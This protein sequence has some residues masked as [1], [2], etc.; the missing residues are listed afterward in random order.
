[1]LRSVLR[2]PFSAP[3]ACAATYKHAIA[4]AGRHFSASGA[5]KPRYLPYT[6]GEIKE[7]SSTGRRVK[8]TRRIPDK[9]EYIDT[10][11]VLAVVGR[12]NVGKSTL[13]N[14][15]AID[16]GDREMLMKSAGQAIA[17]FVPS[18]VDS[19]PGVTR[20]ARSANALLVDL[21]FS[22][23]DT[24]GLEDVPFAEQETAF[25]T[26]QRDETGLVLTMDEDY[27]GNAER[28]T[29]AIS[30]SLVGVGAMDPNE[31]YRAMYRGMLGSTI[32]AIASSDAIMLVVDLSCGV[33]PEDAALTRWVRRLYADKDVIL[34]GNKADAAVAKANFLDVYELGFGEPLAISAEQNTGFE[35]VYVRIKELYRKAVKD[36]ITARPAALGSS[37]ATEPRPS[38][39]MREAVAMERK[40]NA[41]GDI[42]DLLFDPDFQRDEPIRKPI[43]A[44]LGRPNVGKSTLMNRLL[45]RDRTLISPAAGVTRDAVLTEWFPDSSSKESL[46]LVDTAGVRRQTVTAKSRVERLSTKASFQALRTCHIAVLVMDA[47]QPLTDQDMRILDV[48]ITEGRAIVL[49]LNKTDLLQN[50]QTAREVREW[51]DEKIT[52]S[53]HHI[54]GVEVVFMSGKDWSNGRMQAKKLAGAIERARTRWER[55]VPTSALN[56]FVKRFNETVSV[57]I[58]TAKRNRIGVTKFISQRRTRPP[59]FRL[60]GA[61]AVSD[62]YIRSLTN[63][64]RRE[65]GFEGVPIRIKRPSRRGRK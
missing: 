17:P 9:N 10:G 62:N 6:P 49:V 19:F 39:S 20:D 8:R 40:D 7:R 38:E 44:I 26:R 12:P 46:W 1:M 15:L 22:L 52:S 61:S 48:V 14:R 58:A 37:S 42:D 36:S 65:F 28:A 2:R 13:F 3:T 45:P 11:L 25:A 27:L 64:L 50:K 35:D 41:E 32:N 57:S 21:M 59:M 63:A 54:T 23:V 53:L 34:V 60:D 31:E 43:V 29:D 47:T 24:A 16:P 56:R 4:G 51:V 30:Q 5:P 33:T 18:V 55:R